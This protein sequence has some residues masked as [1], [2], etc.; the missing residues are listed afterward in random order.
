[1]ATLFIGIALAVFNFIKP[2][3]EDAYDAIYPII[4]TL[5]DFF[6]TVIVEMYE[7]F[8]EFINAL[9]KGDLEKILM[10]GLM[11]MG[12][13]A[14]TVATGLGI[15]LTASLG[16]ALSLG[17]EL[18]SAGY[19]W[20]SKNVAKALALFGIFLGLWVAWSY[21]DKLKGTPAY[22]MALAGYIIYAI[23][24]HFDFLAEGGPVTTPLQVVGEKGPEIVSLPKGSRVHSNKDSQKMVN[25][26][27]GG[28]GNVIN[29]TVNASGTSDGEIRKIAQKVANII[30]REINRSTS[31]S[32]SR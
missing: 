9:M 22:L 16:L 30:N 3:L 31:S 12:T 18:F 21:I 17:K 14:L 1:M 4:E 19:K 8:I 32:M 11:F 10:H 13:L 2:Y 20:A 7:Q 28:G 6:G 26:N 23:A 27:R 29:V 25:Q 5:R 24:K 15:L